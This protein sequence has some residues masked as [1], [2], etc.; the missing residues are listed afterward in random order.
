MDSPDF[1]AQLRREL[2]TFGACLTGDLA[3]RVE[4]CGDWT[5]YDLAEHLGRSNL[6][7][8]VAVTEKRGDYQAAPAPRDPE[9]LVRWFDST[10]TTLLSALD[11][12]PSAPAWT[13]RPPHTVGFWQR[14]RCLE[15]LV[16]RWDAEHALDAAP[17]LDADLA[18][19]GVA[20]VFD[21]MAP[22]QIDRGTAVAPRHAIRLRATDTGASWTYGPGRP[23][24]TI[25]GSAEHLLL[26]LWGRLSADD[27]TIQW[28]GDRTTGQPVLD[29][30]LVG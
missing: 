23:V 29:G 30:P 7:A 26:L 16:H 25:S 5:L 22:R 21:T 17:R 1:M 9:E 15:T 19:D 24:A 27:E 8:S 11:Q 10:C 14:R 20:E 4:H 13:F 2:T 3:V 6:W 18:A 28:D 12:D